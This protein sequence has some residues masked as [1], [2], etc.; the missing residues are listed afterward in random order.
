LPHGIWI[1]KRA[2]RDPSIVVVDR[3]NHVLQYF[4]LDGQYLQTVS[5]F[6]LPANADTWRD[7]MVVP[8]LFARVSILDRDNKVIARLGEDVSRIKG[9]AQFAIRRDRSQWRIGRFVHPHDACFDAADNI[10][11][12]EWVATGRVTKLERLC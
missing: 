10:F 12:A 3:Q 6:G 4:S 9:D 5:G 1:D 8:E 7:L 11:V 2:G